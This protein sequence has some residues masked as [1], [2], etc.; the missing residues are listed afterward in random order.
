MKPLIIVQSYGSVQYQY[1]TGRSFNGTIYL[2]QGID[3]FTL[4]SALTMVFFVLIL[5]VWYL[6]SYRDINRTILS[7]LKGSK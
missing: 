4:I 7:F 5:G 1:L 6:I 3:L 2:Y